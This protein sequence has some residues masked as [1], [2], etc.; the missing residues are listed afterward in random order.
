MAQS[1]SPWTDF[2]NPNE[3]QIVHLGDF[4]C[5]AMAHVKL[6][7]SSMSSSGISQVSPSRL[8]VGMYFGRCCKVFNGFNFPIHRKALVLSQPLKWKHED[9]SVLC[10]DC[11][12]VVLLVCWR[13]WAS[14]CSLCLCQTS[15]WHQRYP[16][17]KCL[18]TICWCEKVCS[19][20]A[21]NKQ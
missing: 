8:T 5:S 2:I 14:V 9:P 21:Y 13:W 6:S 19:S 15:K 11:G 4:R 17:Y 18:L 20:F 12:Q 10:S 7:R 3:S 16:L 1:R